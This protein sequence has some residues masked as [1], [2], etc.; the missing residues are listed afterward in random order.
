MDKIAAVGIR[1]VFRFWIP[2]A[3]IGDMYRTFD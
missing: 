1:D 2:E 3:I